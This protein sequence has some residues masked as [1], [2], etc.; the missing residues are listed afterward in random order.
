M[1]DSYHFKIAPKPLCVCII[2]V[3]HNT[4]SYEKHLK[5]FHFITFGLYIYKLK[6]DDYLRQVLDDHL[7]VLRLASSLFRHIFFL[8]NLMS[9]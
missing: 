8:D 2:T 6:Q 5:S 7:S 1:K 9:A 3:M 4:R